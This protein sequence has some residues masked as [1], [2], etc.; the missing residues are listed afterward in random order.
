VLAP[1]LFGWS[2]ATQ[3]AIEAL[4]IDVVCNAGR[5][6]TESSALRGRNSAIAVAFKGTGLSTAWYSARNQHWEIQIGW[7]STGGPTLDW[8]IAITPVPTGVP[9]QVAV[10][11][12]TPEWLTLDGKLANFKRH[13]EIRERL[14]GLANASQPL[15]GA[16][17]HDAT[18]HGLNVIN[19]L[20]ARE[21]PPPATRTWTL[22]TGLD[23]EQVTE[24]FS[25]VP[26]P[27][28][29]GEVGWR[30]G[31]SLLAP[32]IGNSIEA[33]VRP[34]GTGTEVKLEMQT[35]P[36]ATKFLDEGV[37]FLRGSG[38]LTIATPVMLR[39]ASATLVEVL[40]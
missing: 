18:N 22:T 38:A 2:A 40:K 12:D 19:E 7:A 21:S 6:N 13:D 32:D 8:L 1:G 29:G 36:A 3:D 25:A 28:I 37:S 23:T 24:A 34:S 20:L 39:D 10:T 17:E 31:L 27:R 35:G 14:R 9:N 33:I 15:I 26:L 5:G 11:V 4:I 16:Y 30:W